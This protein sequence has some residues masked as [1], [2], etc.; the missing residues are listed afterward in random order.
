MRY[1]LS[2]AVIIVLGIFG[3]ALGL[4]AVV[5]TYSFLAG[6]PAG[7]IR[8]MHQTY[9]TLTPLVGAFFKL[10]ALGNWWQETLLP[11][12]NRFMQWALQNWWLLLY[13]A[14]CFICIP[15]VICVYLITNLCL[16]L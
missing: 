10:V 8:G 7:L 1:R 12:L 6:G 14:A 15:V 3:G 13:L 11:L 4:W 16:R 5:I 2:H 9:A